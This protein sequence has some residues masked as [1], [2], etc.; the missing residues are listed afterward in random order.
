MS[1]GPW[2]ILQVKYFSGNKKVGN[3]VYGMVK[4]CVIMKRDMD[5]I[6]KLLLTVEG[7]EHGFASDIEIEGYTQ[8]EIGYHAFLLD[9]AGL[10]VATK[11]TSHGS[12]SP[13][14]RI[15]RLTWQGHE[16][17]DA[18][19]DNRIWSQAKDAIGKI[20]GASLPVWTALL[21]EYIKKNLGI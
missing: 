7:Q 15:H 2:N 20:G 18:A 10:V 4:C 21:T 3:G 6:R 14:A 9:E 13:C 11:L 19:R 12:P 1:R 17:I 16:F 5:L 8:E